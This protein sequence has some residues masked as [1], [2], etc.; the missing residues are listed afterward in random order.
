[1][2]S[3]VGAFDS[4]LIGVSCAVYS[5]WG[6]TLQAAYP[7]TRAAC[8]CD[9]VELELDL[10]ANILTGLNSS[11]Q[12]KLSPRSPLPLG[13]NVSLSAVRQNGAVP[14]LPSEFGGESG[15]AELPS[16][17]AW[18]LQLTINKTAC[19]PRP[20]RVTCSAEHG[21][22]SASGGGCECPTG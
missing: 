1:M 8:L 18:D 7:A 9:T 21:F 11:L 10:T 22:V 3:D 13:T 5:K 17:G 4:T 6:A 2:A 16:I 12:A 15:K 19:A 14:V 20:M